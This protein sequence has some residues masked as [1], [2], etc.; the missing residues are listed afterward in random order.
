MDAFPDLN[1]SGSFTFKAADTA[2]RLADYPEGQQ[3]DLTLY[4]ETTLTFVLTQAEHAIYRAFLQRMGFNRAFTANWVTMLGLPNAELR[5]AAV[6]VTEAQ[7]GYWIV[8]QS[9]AVR[10]IPELLDRDYHLVV[11]A[12]D[13][14][15]LVATQNITV[16][17]RYDGLR[18]PLRDSLSVT[19]IIPLDSITFE[20]GNTRRRKRWHGS[21]RQL[22]C[23]FR[24]RSLRGFW[25]WYAITLRHG[26]APFSSAW[27]DSVMAGAQSLIFMTAPSVTVANGV[28]LISAEFWE[29]VAN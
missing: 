2:R 20:A 28:G 8:Q 24:E 1:P 6:P 22:R 11:A 10:A 3:D 23:R 9:F 5:F 19:E 14:G 29:Y 7:G 21:R 13:K 18:C 26:V 25:A 27:L 12:Q 15:G 16:R 4:G 17:L